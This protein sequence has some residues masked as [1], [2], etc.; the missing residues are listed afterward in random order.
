MSPDCSQPQSMI[1]A[2]ISDTSKELL[3][4][5]MRERSCLQGESSFRTDFQLVF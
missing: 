1:T 3:E 4:G 2:Y 5:N